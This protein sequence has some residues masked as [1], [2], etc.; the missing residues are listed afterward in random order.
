[1]DVVSGLTDGTQQS[2][3]EG[4][5]VGV[6]L[7]FII[8]ERE[9]QALVGEELDQAAMLFGDMQILLFGELQH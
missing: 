9:C 3:E 4:I 6:D 7:G 5:A 8:L 2:E 1:M